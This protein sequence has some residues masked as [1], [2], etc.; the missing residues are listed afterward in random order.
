MEIDRNQRFDGTFEREWRRP[1]GL[2]LQPKLGMA[3]AEACRH[4]DEICDR[5]AGHPPDGI[6]LRGPLGTGK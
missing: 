6:L 1:G 5:R 2:H 4:A 3:L